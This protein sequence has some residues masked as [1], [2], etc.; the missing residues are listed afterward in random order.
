M[1][2]SDGGVSLSLLVPLTDATPGERCAIN[3]DVSIA[4]D[5]PLD[6]CYP[7]ERYVI[8]VDITT[9]PIVLRTSS[10]PGEISA[11]KL[12]CRTVWGFS[13]IDSAPGECGAVKLD[14]RWASFPPGENDVEECDYIRP[15]PLAGS[16][17][18]PRTVTGSL[19][20]GYPHISQAGIGST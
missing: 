10:N 6:G 3:L 17:V 7:G 19:L 13:Q 1:S 9:V 2:Q 12:G 14:F 20:F 8:G 5:F 16:S 11:V 4:T 18:C 15:A